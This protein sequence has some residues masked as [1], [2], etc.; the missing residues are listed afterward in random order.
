MASVDRALG[1][2][3]MVATLI[4]TGLIW[5]YP[6]KRWIGWIFVSSGVIAL[7]IYVIHLIVTSNKKERPQSQQLPEGGIHIYNNPN[8]SPTFSPQFNH[9]LSPSQQH[10][11]TA[12]NSS[13]DK[14]KRLEIARRLSEQLEAGRKI[15]RE[16]AR[17]ANAPIA[18]AVAWEIDT[19]VYIEEN[20]G[21]SAALVFGR[22]YPTI[23]YPD[24]ANNREL[25]DR[26]HTKLRRLGDLI[27]DILN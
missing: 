20:L 8:I 19:K 27:S 16:C 2:A 21:E 26:L 1:V 25:V 17:H 18:N 13:I 6:E 15:M 4:G 5:L 3:G 22:A 23:P 24:L 14:E 12:D 11:F 10:I 7:L 9:P